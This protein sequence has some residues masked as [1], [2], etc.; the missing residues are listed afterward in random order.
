VNIHLLLL[1]QIQQQVQRPLI[2]RY[3][4][5][6]RRRHFSL[7]C[8]AQPILAVLF[9]LAFVGARYIVPPPSFSLLLPS[10]VMRVL[11]AKLLYLSF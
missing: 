4:N 1:D 10:T 5:F 6:V 7:S 2:H 11:L 3:I 8:V 9:C